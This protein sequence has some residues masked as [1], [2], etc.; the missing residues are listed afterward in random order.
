MK[1]PL[2]YPEFDP[3]LNTQPTLWPQ[4]TGLSTGGCL[5]RLESLWPECN[6][7]AGLCSCMF[8]ELLCLPMERESG[9]PARCVWVQGPSWPP[10]G[11]FI[12][13]AALVDPQEHVGRKIRR[14]TLDGWEPAERMQR[15]TCGTGMGMNA[16]YTNEHTHK[17]SSDGSEY[18]A[19]TEQAFFS[20]FFLRI[21][22]FSLHFWTG[23]PATFSAVAL[24]AGCL[25]FPA[26]YVQ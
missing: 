1:V 18:I 12:I 13:R 25:G 21:F 5:S 9:R 26:S 22:F 2:F 11:W 8:V 3:G 10:M 17:T 6:K 7:L 23:V 4:Y 24:S 20:L 19:T 16:L 15:G 14:M